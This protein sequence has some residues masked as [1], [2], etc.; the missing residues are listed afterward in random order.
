MGNKT[1]Q[2]LESVRSANP[3][4]KMTDSVAWFNTNV[5]KLFNAKRKIPVEIG[6]MYMFCYDPIGKQNLPYWDKYPL[7]IVCEIGKNTIK[8]LNV[9]YIPTNIRIKIMKDIAEATNES[10]MSEKSKVS[11]IVSYLSKTKNYTY[12]VKQYSGDGVRSNI[13]NIPGEHWGLACAL[14]MAVI[15]PS[16][17]S[18]K[19][20]GPISMGSLVHRKTETA[21]MVRW[22]GA[23]K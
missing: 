4:F 20:A 5:A 8:G 12:M 9:H 19:K 7:V 16:T 3:N 2:F 22:A 15:T 13:M 14:P 18:I 11:T 1:N 23:N 10:V 17:G 6:K 21:A